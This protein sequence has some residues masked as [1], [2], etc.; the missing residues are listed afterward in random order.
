MAND[1]KT[2]S[3]VYAYE[4]RPWGQTT[5]YGVAV[6]HAGGAIGRR[7]AVAGL[8]WTMR[9]LFYRTIILFRYVDTYTLDFMSPQ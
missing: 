8:Y 3:M 4:S 7:L 2:I 1:E 5:S 6:H 9:R